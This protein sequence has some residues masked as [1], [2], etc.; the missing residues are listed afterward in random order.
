MTDPLDER[1]EEMRLLMR[2]AQAGDGEAYATLLQLVSRRVRQMVRARRRG[3]S[4]EHVED[5]TQ[6]VLM[7]VHTARATFDP[8][9]AFAPWLA[10]IVRYRLADA[11]RRYSR[12]GAHEVA[13]A[14]PDVTFTEPATNTQP[15][16]V[17]GDPLLLAEAMQGLSP[18]QRQAIELLKLQEMSLKEASAATGLSQGALKL[19]THRAMAALRRALLRTSSQ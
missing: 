12:Q 11:A 2:Q 1:D 18:G 3:L 7:S 15:G 16:D 10:A 9:R 13:V 6:E 5:L 8:S 14:D 19:A 17:Y 4:E